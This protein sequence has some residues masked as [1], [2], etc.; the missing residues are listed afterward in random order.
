MEALEKK[1]LLTEMILNQL[2]EAKLEPL[3]ALKLTNFVGNLSDKNVDLFLDEVMLSMRK[4][5]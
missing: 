3:E 2:K 4:K 5:K 1:Q